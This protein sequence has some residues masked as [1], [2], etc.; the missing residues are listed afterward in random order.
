M[1]E[2]NV[3]FTLSGMLLR[4]KGMEGTVMLGVLHHNKKGQF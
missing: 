2:Q 3:V 4:F 1:H